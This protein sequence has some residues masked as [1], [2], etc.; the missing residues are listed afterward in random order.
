M[1]SNLRIQPK[2][3]YHS[4]RDIYG[5]HSSI[6]YWRQESWRLF[7]PLAM[8]GPTISW[9]RESL[10]SSLKMSSLMLSSALLNPVSSATDRSPFCA[11]ENFSIELL[12]KANLSFPVGRE[13]GFLI[14]SG[15]TPM[16]TPL[17]RLGL[18][19]YAEL[20]PNGIGA[21]AAVV[22]GRL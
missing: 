8:Q 21:L 11:P 6:S 4:K 19:L 5:S 15:V 17:K 22:A 18:I 12:S 1:L 10:Q 20:L 13:G 7:L 16:P 2:T 3:P 14:S 9:H